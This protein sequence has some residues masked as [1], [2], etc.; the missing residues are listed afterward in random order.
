MKKSSD[1]TGPKNQYPKGYFTA[2]G[3]VLG[4]PLA[5]I[6]GI[7]LGNFALGPTLGLPIGFSIGLVAEQVWNK[8]PRAFSPGE[9]QKITRISLWL[10]LLGLAVFVSIYF[11]VR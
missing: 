8:N 9:F 11:Y 2:I 5:I 3:M 1:Q 7:L 10:L 4:I 6:M